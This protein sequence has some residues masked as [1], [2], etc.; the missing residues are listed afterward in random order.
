[1]PVEIN[2]NGQTALVTGGTRGIGKDIALKL[3]EAG[4]SL[5]LTGTKLDEIE[6][7]NREN[8]D[9]S[10]RYLQLNLLDKESILS[11]LKELERV[12]K[13]EILINNAGVNRIDQLVNTSDEDYDCIFDVNLKGV[14]RISREIGKMMVSQ[15]YGRIVNI[16]SIWGV[17]TRNG[18]SLYAASKHGLVGLTKTMAIECAKHD[19]L[20]N[21]LSPG[22]TLTDLTYQT[23]TPEELNNMSKAIPQERMAEPEEMANVVLFLASKLN[24]YI[25]GQNIVVDGGYTNV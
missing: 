5:I 25:V 18:R 11:F 2:L 14:Y 4:A 3:K 19:V 9:P 10:V 8:K 13:I 20:V 22:F 24:T 16:A 12:G 21:C 17:I 6:L 15:G 7:L 1:M 23:N